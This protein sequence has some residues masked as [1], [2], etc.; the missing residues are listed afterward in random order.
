MKFELQKID[1]NT[2]AA[3]A[4]C[5]EVIIV[6]VPALFYLVYFKINYLDWW[7]YSHNQNGMK[8]VIHNKS[9]SSVFLLKQKLQIKSNS[10]KEHD[11]PQ[12]SNSEIN[13]IQIKPDEFIVI[14]VDFGFY[15]ITPNCDVFLH[16]KF[17]GKRKK[18]II[19]QKKCKRG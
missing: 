13:S 17:G 3:I 4:T 10:N 15:N 16:L 8:I 18:T 14:N 19:L 7:I 6:L 11:I 2:I 12:K 5:M 1:W 9:K